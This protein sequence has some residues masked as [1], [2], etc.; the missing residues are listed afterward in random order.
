MP[1]IKDYFVGTIAGISVD[2]LIMRNI[3]KVV[4][5]RLKSRLILP[6]Q[7]PKLKQLLGIKTTVYVVNDTMTFLEYVLSTFNKIWISP[8][9]RFHW[10]TLLVFG[11]THLGVYYPVLKYMIPCCLKNRS[12]NYQKQLTVIPQVLLHQQCLQTGNGRPDQKPPK[13]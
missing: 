2:S 6:K 4:I 12:F 3:Q 7:K 10:R 9:G 1:G 11:D 5:T 13:E 8:Y